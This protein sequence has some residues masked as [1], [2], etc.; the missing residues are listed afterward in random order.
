[1]DNKFFTFISPYL[2]FIDKGHL[3][4]KPF[5][6]L[7][8][9]MA[10]GNLLVPVYSLLK[11]IDNRIFNNEFKIILAFLL[12]WLIIAF[13]AWVSFQLWWDRKSKITF[14]SDDNSEFAAT[15]A[16]SHLIQ[17][18]G[19]W[20]GTWIGLVGFGFALL[21]TIFWGEGNYYLNYLLGIPMGEYSS[22]EWI[23]I[24][25]MP[26]QGFLIV[27]LTRFIAEQIK[28]ISVIANNT[29]K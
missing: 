10:I 7:Y 14:S 6:W 8:V 1:M 9:I 3:F 22:F 12:A 18:L 20:L 16:L 15:P 17:T 13:A 21:T 4:K 27:V 23:G 19:E 26:I 25:T 29:K 28:A 5:S 11:V 2:S 24:I